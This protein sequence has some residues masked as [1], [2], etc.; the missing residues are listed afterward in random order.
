MRAALKGTVLNKEPTIIKGIVH[1]NITFLSLF[2]PMD[3][4]DAPVA[5]LCLY[6]RGVAQVCKKIS[7]A[8]FLKVRDDWGFQVNPLCRHDITRSD[9]Q[10]GNL[11]FHTTSA[12]PQTDHLHAT[13]N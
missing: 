7:L 4:Q 5:L 11:G 1:P 12:V 6:A 10:I 8:F 9:R 2:T 13:P 3:A